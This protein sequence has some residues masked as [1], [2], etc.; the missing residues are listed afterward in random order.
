MRI[1]KQEENVTV[2]NVE[3]YLNSSE[4]PVTHK[5]YHELSESPVHEL[6]AL[7]QLHNNLEMLTDLSGRLTFL[8]REVRYM[9]KA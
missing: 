3:S 7:A 5:S 4:S 6:D 8:M 1:I 2:S 9:L